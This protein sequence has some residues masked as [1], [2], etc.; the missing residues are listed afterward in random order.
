[1]PNMILKIHDVTKHCGVSRTWLYA[2]I[3]RGEFPAQVELGPRSVGWLESDI[4]EWI[5][6][7][8]KKQ[9]AKSVQS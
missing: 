9:D 8:P 2:A 5:S 3:Q 6:S 7:R 1:M 4:Q